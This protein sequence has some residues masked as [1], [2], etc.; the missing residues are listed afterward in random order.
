MGI[1]EIRK[2]L[3]G[4]SPWRAMVILAIVGL[5]F[6]LISE[7]AFHPEGEFLAAVEFLELAGLLVI[8]IDLAVNF[9]RADSKK[10]FLRES[11]L[12][13][14]LFIPFSFMFQAFRTY[15]VFE[16]MGVEA[17]PFLMRTKIAVKGGHIAAHVGRSGPAMAAKRTITEMMGIP[18][19]YRTMRYRGMLNFGRRT[20]YLGLLSIG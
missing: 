11:W 10:R 3:A 1:Q 16:I 6:A 9:S 5:A 15:E 7:L 17:M 13:L 19:R 4:M 14:M 8:F 2:P 12:E 20:Q 18:N